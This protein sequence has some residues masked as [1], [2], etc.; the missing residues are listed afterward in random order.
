MN[1]SRL[2]H[3]SFLALCLVINAC[4][5]QT[6]DRVF[7]INPDKDY[8]EFAVPLNH[9]FDIR[10]IRLGGEGQHYFI[11]TLVGRNVY[12]DDV[13]QLIFLS[14]GIGHLTSV[15]V[16]DFDGNFIRSIGKVGRGPG[17][18]CSEMISILP[19]P[20]EKHLLV[21]DKYDYK[22]I[23]YD[24]EGNYI[25]TKQ[26]DEEIF[27][28]EWVRS[29]DKLLNY[30]KQKSELTH[31]PMLCIFCIEDLTLVE[32]RDFQF[33][34]PFDFKGYMT[35]KVYS[36]GAVPTDKGVW[37]NPS[38]CSD[39]TY[40]FQH[41]GRIVPRV[42]NLT[43]NTAEHILSLVFESPEYLFC[44]YRDD[45]HWEKCFVIRK[46]DGA[47]FKIS[48][49]Q[50]SFLTFYFFNATGDGMRCILPMPE[51]QYKNEL[52]ALDPNAKPVIDSFDEEGNPLLVIFSLK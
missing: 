9:I 4:T 25:E 27:G 42:V 6:T 44:R 33:P 46:S 2:I 18:F 15:G 52:I 40:F 47:V 23:L 3:S 24:Y 26:F 22:F 1:C 39:T 32:K 30:E 20:E 19:I 50:L 37:L 29:G 7:L 12:F 8:P 13:N 28:G 45:T 14:N 5:H 36:T 31:Q 17:E 48:P 51:I 38:S 10:V 35:Y 11:R 16:F 49:Q 41:D 21:I 34:R 43:H